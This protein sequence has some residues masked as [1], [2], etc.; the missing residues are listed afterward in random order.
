MGAM[1]LTTANPK[2]R[3]A[4]ISESSPVPGVPLELLGERA[5]TQPMGMIGGQFGTP[6]LTEGDG[7]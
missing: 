1:W 3:P 5:P 2:S 4:P 7:N 6:R